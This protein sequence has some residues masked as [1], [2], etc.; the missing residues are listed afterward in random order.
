MHHKSLGLLPRVIIAIIAG[1][2]AGFLAPEIVVKIFATINGIFSNFLSFCIPLVIMGLTISGIADLGTG[3]GKLLLVTAGLAY[4]STVFSGFLTYFSSGIVFPHIISAADKAVASVDD[5]SKALI[6]PIFTVGMPPVFDVTTALILAFILGIGISSIGGTTLKN[7]VEEFKKI[8]EKIIENALIPFLPLYVFGI[9]INMSFTGEAFQV[10]S[11][12]GKVIVF[13]LALSVVLLLIQFIA[14]GVTAKA[15]PLKM[16]LTMLPA[17][18]TA[19]GT[20]S[21]AAT[22]PVTLEQTKKMG[23]AEDI[24]DFCVPLCATIHMAGSTMK[25]TG[26]ALAILA[27]QGQVPSFSVIAGFICMLGITM[28]AAPAVPGGAVMAALGVLK[29]ALG[30]TPE[31][32][33]LMIAVYVAIDS[34]GTACN[35]TGDG[36]ISVMVN[37]IAGNKLTPVSENSGE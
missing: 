35:V 5:P 34:F 20:S 22:I 11:V 23:V 24:A 9:F 18:F 26:M 31:N 4:I 13:I 29:S 14:A 2:A 30:F 8:T 15:D 6:G 19:L 7:G 28:V 10:I 27:L 3:A 25:I 12:F 32:L 1:T 33:A 37:R 36:A 21:S 16:L 17:Y